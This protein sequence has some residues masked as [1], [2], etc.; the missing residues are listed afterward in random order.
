GHF[1]REC[2]E[3]GDS[4]S[5]GKT[6]RKCGQEGHFARDC[7]SGG[8]GS[9]VCYKCNKPGHISRDCTEESFEGGRGGQNC[10]RCNKPG[11]RAF[12]CTEE[13]DGGKTLNCFVCGSSEHLSAKC[14]SKVR[15][16]A[17]PWENPKPVS[18]SSEEAWEKLLQA[19][20]ER[21]I[22][23]FKEAFEEYAKATPEETFQS[24]EKKLRVANCTGRIIAL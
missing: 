14:P 16:T 9:G 7:S 10:F 19:D 4:F 11:H 23:D 20:K 15:K 17:T 1:A 21:D 5:S 12:E 13:G 6:C 8:G 18:I 3:P 24:I 2:N 22:D